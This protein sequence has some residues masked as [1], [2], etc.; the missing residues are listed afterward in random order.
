[1]IKGVRYWLALGFMLT[2][3]LAL[4]YVNLNEDLRQKFKDRFVPDER[5]VLAK[6]LGR[7]VGGGRTFT[8]L[9]VKNKN[10]LSLE[11][12]EN[13]FSTNQSLFRTRLILP[14]HRDAYFSYLGAAVNLLLVDLKNDGRL[15]VVTAAFD[16]NLVPRMHVYSYD[17]ASNTLEPIN[18]DEF[19]L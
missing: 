17:D 11:V 9:K 14:E 18:Q 7:L 3:S 8:V 4:A 6:T 12:F 2:L 15:E 1:M 19:H 5:V 13:N 10:T 16:E